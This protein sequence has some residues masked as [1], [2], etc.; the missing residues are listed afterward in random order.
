MNKIKEFVL[1]FSSP[2]TRSVYRNH[3]QQFLKF[4]GE[5]ENTYFSS[6]R[7][8]EDDIKR[9]WQYIQ[10]RPPKSIK[11]IL[12]C[13]KMFLEEFDV[14]I[15]PK[16][17]RNISR[18]TPGSSAVSEDII[19]SHKELKE[20]LQYAP[21]KD[22]ALFLMMVSSGMREGEA[23][24]IRLQDI[25]FNSAPVKIKVPS[26]TKDGKFTKTGD[27][28]TTFMTNEARD[29]VQA[30][31][32]QRKRYRE[33]ADRKGLG[34]MRWQRMKFGIE[35]NANDINRVFP[36][37]AD[38]AR[39][40][41]NKLIEKAGYIE[42]D[43]ITNVHKMRLH[44][45]RK[46]FEHQLKS[47]IRPGAVE[48]IVGHEGYLSTYNRFTDKELTDEYLKG[49]DVLLIFETSKLD[50]EHRFQE[51][52]QMM[53]DQIDKLNREIETILDKASD[54]VEE[55]LKREDFKKM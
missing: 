23:V 16:V 55:R 7:N 8:Y 40:M 51:R 2:S 15:R 46:F 32:K 12:S 11:S 6:G 5:D 37:S 18:R 19:P 54:M 1:N 21:L 29:A 49:M 24:K 53:Q 27:K 14:V 13:I 38:T 34:L 25:D 44:T 10:H 35:H 17:W 41:W 30:W 48:Q 31:L 52:T 47:K 33:S 9:Y 39:V 45:L 20:I 42:R 36:F 22:R 28:R 26:F 4:L 3:I 43:E 50:I